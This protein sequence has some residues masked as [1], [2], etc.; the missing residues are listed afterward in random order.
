MITVCLLH[1]LS[2]HRLVIT[3]P[4]LG[5]ISYEMRLKEYGLTTLETRRL[6]GNQIEMFKILN[7]YF[8]SI[9][10]G[11]RTRGHGVTL[12]KKQCRLYIRSLHMYTSKTGFTYP[13]DRAWIKLSHFTQFTITSLTQSTQFTAVVIVVPLRR[14]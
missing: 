1:Y 3:W 6:R 9:K 13:N 5:N 11:R 2:V 8:F 14:D 10:E 7:E 4:K 12:A